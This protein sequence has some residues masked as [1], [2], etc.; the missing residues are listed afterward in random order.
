MAGVVRAHRP[1]TPDTHLFHI[2][3]GNPMRDASGFA[4]VF[5]KFETSEPDGAE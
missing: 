4:G 3:K 2:T 5:P 1:R